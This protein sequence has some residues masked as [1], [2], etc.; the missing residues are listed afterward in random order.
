VEESELLLSGAMRRRFFSRTGFAIWIGASVGVACVLPYVE[1]LTPALG[2]AA[3]RLGLPVALVVLLSLL[4]SAAMLGVMTF[5]GLWAAGK[6][7]LGAPWLDAWLGGTPP[8]ELRRAAFT[9][10]ALGLAVGVVLLALDVF[11]FLPLSPNA[12]GQ[13]LR[14]PQPPAW[15]G[16]LASFEGGIS[17]EVELR[18]FLLSFLAL[19]LRRASSLVAGARGADLTPAIFWTANV[20]AAVLFGLGHLPVTSHLI[21]LTALIVTRAIVLNGLVGLLTGYL[22][23]RRG[24]EMAMLCHFCADI[25]LHVVAPLLQPLLL[26]VAP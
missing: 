22:F 8:P 2:Q 23:W 3:T 17:E 24:I 6:L 5:S 9:A 21:P 15:T 13:L 7:S 4:Q 10:V 19:G 18:L 26:R 14:Q 11:L 16:L 1:A 20:I 12:V 25:I